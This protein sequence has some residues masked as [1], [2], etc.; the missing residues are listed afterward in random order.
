M[1]AADIMQNQQYKFGESIDEEEAEHQKIIWRNF[2]EFDVFDCIFK[3]SD[4]LR[5]KIFY[6]ISS[7]YSCFLQMVRV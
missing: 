3:T 1:L 6:K 7:N 2:K 5:Q 4:K